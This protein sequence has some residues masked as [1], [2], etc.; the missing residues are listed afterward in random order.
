MRHDSV[1]LA[2]ERMAKAGETAG[3]VDDEAKA[4]AFAVV[5]GSMHGRPSEHG[6][7]R[8]RNRCYTCAHPRYC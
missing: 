4:A 6:G 7:R 3:Q 1:P 2:R 8:V 5:L